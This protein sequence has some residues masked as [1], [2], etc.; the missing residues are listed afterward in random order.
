VLL[1]IN[2]QRLLRR[3]LPLLWLQ[4]PLLVLVQQLL[5]QKGDLLQTPCPQGA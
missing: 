4:C 2:R 5:M 1:H 3:L